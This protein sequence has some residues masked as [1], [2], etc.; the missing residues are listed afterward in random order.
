MVLTNL[1]AEC[2]CRHDQLVHNT[3]MTTSH[4]LAVHAAMVYQAV[5]AGY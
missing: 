5:R 2:F 4:M 1:A 3:V